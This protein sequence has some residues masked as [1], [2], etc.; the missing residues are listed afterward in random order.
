MEIVAVLILIASFTICAMMVYKVHRIE[1]KQDKPE[2]DV[3]TKTLEA[4]NAI[5]WIMIIQIVFATLTGITF[6][7]RMNTVINSI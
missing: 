5:K 3:Q 7:I 4:V 6:I 2:K 1:P